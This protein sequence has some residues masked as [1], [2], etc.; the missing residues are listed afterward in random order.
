MSA[1]ID[2]T[3]FPAYGKQEAVI[4]WKVQEQYE[5]GV[6]FI[7][8]SNTGVAPWVL[9]NPEGTVGD[10]YI[11]TT[12][13][14]DNRTDITHYRIL[15]EHTDGEFDSPVVGI[16]DKL[17]RREYAGARRIQTLEF[18]RMQV[19]DG[20]PMFLYKP[21]RRGTPCPHADA[22]TGQLTAED[23]KGTVNELGSSV[24]C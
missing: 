22:E 14:P 5:D 7:Y 13:K 8:R 20:L 19:S 24:D 23:C 15:L 11:D 18:K 16:Y 2:I 17:T 1:F 10:E 6:F 21:L 12:L 4:R 9:L 3:I